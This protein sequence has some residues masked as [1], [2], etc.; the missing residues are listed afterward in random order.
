[1]KKNKEDIALLCRLDKWLWAARF[2]KTRKLASDSIKEG[3]ISI[4]GKTLVKPSST[5]IPNNIIFINNDYMRRKIIVK[6]LPIKRE[7]FNQAKKVYLIVEEKSSEV[8]EYFERR[9]LKKSQEN[10]KEKN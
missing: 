10:K 6:E 1:M 2:Y 9:L 4:E 7:S 3:N 8:K 5:I